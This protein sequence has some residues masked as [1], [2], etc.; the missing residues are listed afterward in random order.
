MDFGKILASLMGVLMIAFCL[1]TSVLY[2]LPLYQK[3]QLDQLCRDYLYA[4]N[5][6]D[7]MTVAVKTTLIRELEAEGLTDV[8]VVAPIEGT[9]K[10]RERQAFQ[11]SGK[12]QLREASGFLQFQSKTVVYEFKGWVYGKRI[13]N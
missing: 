1:V 9:L 4:V 7:G 10:R 3:I 11:V 13:I 8:G 2:V 5:A 6:S 12:L